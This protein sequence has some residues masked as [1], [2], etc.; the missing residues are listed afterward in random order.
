MLMATKT[1][2]VATKLQ[3]HYRIR[4]TGMCFQ[5]ICVNWVLV[6]HS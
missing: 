5:D 6:I 4:K 3:K 1:M 2:L